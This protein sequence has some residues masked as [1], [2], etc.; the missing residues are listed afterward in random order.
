MT[1]TS[2]VRL[3]SGLSVSTAIPS[4]TCSWWMT[5]GAALGSSASGGHESGV[6]DRRGPEGLDDGVADEVGEADLAGA[7]GP[8]ELVVEDAAVD[9]EQPGRHHPEAGGGRDVQAGG[10]VGHDPAGRPAERSGL[11]G[12]GSAAAGG[13][14][15]GRDGGG[16]AAGAGSGV[17]PAAG[18]ARQPMMP[19]WRS[20]PDPPGGGVAAG[21]SPPGPSRSRRRR[22]ARREPRPPEDGRAA[23]VAGVL[24]RIRAAADLRER[25]SGQVGPAGR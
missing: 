6:H 9:L 21:D 24:G 16:D 12:A 7:A 8:A 3:P 15:A 18:R 10:H 23:V 17:E 2:S 14:G 4:P 11:V 5:D 19:G 22:R 1:G 13:R 25:R 20:R